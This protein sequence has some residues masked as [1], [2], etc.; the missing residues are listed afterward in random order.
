MTSAG[1]VIPPPAVS[2]PVASTSRV[3]ASG[4]METRRRSSTQ[5][6]ATPLKKKYKC[7]KCSHLPFLTKFGLAE[8]INIKLQSKGIACD[9]CGNLMSADHLKDHK[10]CH[11]L[12]NRYICE[13]INKKMGKMCLTGCKQKS[14]IHRHIKNVHGKTMNKVK[15]KIIDRSEIEYESKE[16]YEVGKRETHMT[17]E[18]V[19]TL[20]QQFGEEV[21]VE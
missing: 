8:H 11:T 16:D 2:V 9:I 21:M 5:P 1:P 6:D 14:G 3:A 18:N 20:V 19:N 12:S 15:V 10:D 7:V 4:R 17:A 13:E